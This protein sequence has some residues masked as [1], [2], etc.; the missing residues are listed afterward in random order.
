MR[1]LIFILC[2]FYM[3]FG[4][5]APVSSQIVVMHTA[6]KP[7][8]LVTAKDPQFTIK[9]Q[10]NPTTGYSWFLREYDSSLIQPLKR[11]FIPATDKKLIGAPGVE[12]LTFKVK[13]DG[14]IVP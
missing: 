3:P 2:L 12:L 9:L 14:F 8:I 11:V 10:S 6:D 7:A 1:I 5:A 13:P 4:L